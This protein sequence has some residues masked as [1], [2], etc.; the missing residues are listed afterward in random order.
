[1]GILK[2]PSLDSYWSE[3][4]L[5]RVDAFQLVM[6]RDRFMQILHHLHLADNDDVPAENDKLAKFRPFL[7]LLNKSCQQS[8][9]LASKVSIDEGL[10]AF[11]G[12]L[13]FK[14][15]MPD[16]PE[17][18]GIKLWKLCDSSGFMYKCDV[19]TGASEDTEMDESTVES[20]VRSL[21]EDISDQY[22]YHLFAD[23]FYSSIPLALKLLDKKIYFTGTIRENRKY[24][25]KVLKDFQLDNKGDCAWIS[26]EK[27]LVLIKFLD[28][29]VVYLI[30]TAH[31]GCPKSTVPR[32]DK[33]GVM[34]DRVIPTIVADYNQ[35]MGSVDQH[36]Q[37]TVYY[38][39][40]RR[41]T[42]WWQSV[43]FYM[44]SAIVSN[45]WITY[46]VLN[47]TSKMGLL[48]FQEHVILHLIGDFTS[49]TRI[50]TSIGGEY[51]PVKKYGHTREKK[52]NS[53]K[54]PCRFCGKGR[55]SFYCSDC[56]V[57][58]HEKCFDS[59]CV[60]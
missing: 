36:N 33:N 39:Y 19:Y 18:W 34:V 22:P 48:E 11:Q 42:K 5:Y 41:C 51:V 43:F 40:G 10:V 3:S 58:V 7:N 26:S 49:R 59:H 13:A 37:Y 4:K 16:K 53:K 25:P 27:G 32:K 47:P 24:I 57:P 45:A 23:N 30:S 15:Y 2:L 46:K 29:K 17:K 9:V 52:T 56:D 60:E 44:V 21:T 12:R 35:S 14:Q 38:T 20:V 1:M 28:T 50:K 55:P 31:T 6:T 54:I 8:W